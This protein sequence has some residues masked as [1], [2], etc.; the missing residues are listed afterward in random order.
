LLSRERGERFRERAERDREG[1]RAERVKYLRGK[2]KEIIVKN[3]G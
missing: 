1:E 3:S 2:G